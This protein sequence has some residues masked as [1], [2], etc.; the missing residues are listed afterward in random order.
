MHSRPPLRAKE[1]VVVSCQSNDARADECIVALMPDEIDVTNAAWVWERLLRLARTELPLV[2][3]DMSATSFCGLA[4]VHVL[5]RAYARARTYHCELRLVIGAAEVR[6]V[7][8]LAAADQALPIYP[9]LE[10]ARRAPPARAGTADR[11][12]RQAAGRARTSAG[13]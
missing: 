12:A 11:S 3:V 5:T 8:E 6:Q 10:T 4:G 1:R 13:D 9:D 7:F 2:I